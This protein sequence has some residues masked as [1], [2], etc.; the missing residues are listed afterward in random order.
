MVDRRMEAL[1]ERQHSVVSH[2]QARAL[3]LTKEARL[4]LHRSGRWEVVFRGVY[5]LAGSNPTALQLAMAAVL[6][7]GPDALLSHTSAAGLLRLPG[8]GVEPL[9]ITIPRRRRSLP[10][11]RLEQSLCLPAHHRRMVEGITCTSIARTLFDL[12]GD[13]NAARAERALD[14]AL[15]RKRVTIPALWRVLDDLAVQGRSGV[16]LLRRLLTERGERYVPPESELEAHFLELVR[17]YRLP[18]PARQVDLGDADRWIG[19]FDFVWLA[20]GLV[21]EVDGAA[22]HDGLLDRRRD[23]ERSA[24]LESIG[25]TVLRFRWH[26]VVEAPALVITQIRDSFRGASV[27][28]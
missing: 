23:E 7:G 5:R 27:G 19:R 1:A 24:H 8:F 12:C 28:S 16:V 21:V 26:D 6:A 22:Y 14:N 2:D 9:V 20:E 3:G 11:V 18:A 4:H 17:S 10:G 15:A 25:W 13:L